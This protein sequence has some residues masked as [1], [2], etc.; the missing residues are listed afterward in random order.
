MQRDVQPIV[1]LVSKISYAVKHNEILNDLG[2]ITLNCVDASPIIFLLLLPVN[3]QRYSIKMPP[4][5]LLSTSHWK[6]YAG[7][8]LT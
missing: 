2:E 7:G 3:D 8:L 1:I 5:S 4:L 6:S